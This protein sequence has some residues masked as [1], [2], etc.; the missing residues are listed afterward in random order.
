[1]LGNQPDESAIRRSSTSRAAGHEAEGPHIVTDGRPVSVSY[2][3]CPDQRPREPTTPAPRLAT[4]TPPARR[5]CWG[6]TRTT[7]LTTIAEHQ[8]CSTK[9]LAARAG[10][11]PASASEH[12]SVLREAGLIYSL[13]HRNSVLHS[14]TPF[15]GPGVVPFYLSS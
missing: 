11:A 5:R 4:R 9:E 1:M 10:I 6:R 3:A 8:G 2:P 12:A 14:L 7:V 15:H 13:R